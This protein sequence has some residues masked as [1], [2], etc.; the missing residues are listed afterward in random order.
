[1]ITYLKMH[2]REP[3]LTITRLA[4]EHGISERYAYLILSRNGIQLADWIRAERLAGAAQALRD[5]SALPQPI[6]TIAKSWG[7]ADQANFT[8]A[9][10]RLYAMSPREYRHTR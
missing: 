6:A 9:F 1:M 5:P 4:R 8:R 2:L 10:R 7:F 3:D